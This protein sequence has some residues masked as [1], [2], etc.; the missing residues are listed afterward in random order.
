M[1]V[2][3][4]DDF[5][6]T[7]RRSGLLTDEQIDGFL[8]QPLTSP[9]DPAA[10]SQSL[11]DANLLTAWQ[12]DKLLEGRHKGFFLG[13][14]RIL[15]QLGAGAMGSVFLAEH[16]LMRH[17]VA[18]KVLARRLLGKDAYIRR[19][20][21]EARAAAAVNHPR[22][23]RAFDFD[24]AGETYYLVMEYA[25]GEDL[26]KIV[27]RDGVLPIAVAARCIQQTAEGLSAAHAAGLVH[28]DIKPSNLL[29][30][31]AG[32]VRILDLGLARIIDESEPSLT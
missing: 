26:Q 13:K 3:T 28:R 19:F 9:D 30:D 18:I 23:V 17:K 16:K 21:Q 20:E 15:S 8:A 2:A 22:V 14:Y 11:L 5:V 29:V 7:L 32:N 12:R 4:T 6:A 25:E 24:C 31:Q 27:L 1:P 10:L